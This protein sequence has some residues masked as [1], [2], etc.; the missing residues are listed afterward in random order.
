MHDILTLLILIGLEIILGLDNLIYISIVVSRLPVRRQPH[1]R[2]IGLALA[3]ISR[4][5]LLWFAFWL[6]TLVTPLFSVLNHP[7]SARDLVFLIGGLFL[8]VNSIKEFHA[9]FKTVE[10]VAK[11]ASA[12]FHW[13]ILNIMIFDIIFSLDSVITAIGI[14]KDFWIMATAIIVAVLFMLFAVNWVGRIVDAYPAG[15]MSVVSEIVHLK[16]RR[17]PPTPTTF[18]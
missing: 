15:N 9:T 4:L 7:F 18:N 6:S 3:M 10:E 17:R 8:F 11:E 13:A 5:V 12:K 14:A 1:A 16:S 2:R